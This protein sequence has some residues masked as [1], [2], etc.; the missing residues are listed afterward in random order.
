MLS[1]IWRNHAHIAFLQKTHFKASKLSKLGN[2]R[3]PFVYH[4]CSPDSKSHGVSV[5]ISKNVAIRDN[6]GQYIF[7]KGSI[8]RQ[9]VTRV[10]IYT[11]NIGQV[12]FIEGCLDKLT[13]FAEGQLILGGDLNVALDPLL[14]ISTGSSPL[15]YVALH[16]IMK[17]LKAVHLVDAWRIVH[18]DTRNY[19]FFFYPLTTLTRDWIIF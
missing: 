3:Y 12:G 7:V 11:P 9:V 15:S 5:L 2:S 14:D 1:K 6:L 10:N 13:D 4:S 17:A 19:T 8:Y 18:S 16:R